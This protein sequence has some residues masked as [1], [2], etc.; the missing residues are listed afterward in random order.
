MYSA[1]QRRMISLDQIG[2]MDCCPRDGSFS[3]T[4]DSSPDQLQSR[5][6]DRHQQSEELPLKVKAPEGGKMKVQLCRNFI[7]SGYCPYGGKCRFAHG[8]KQLLQNSELSSN[9]RTKNCKAFYVGGECRY[10][11]RCNFKHDDRKLCD[12]HKTGGLCRFNLIQ[13][14]PDLFVSI[15]K[16]PLF[17]FSVCIQS[18]PPVDS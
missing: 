14:Y 1:K 16:K 17:P 13:W 18:E 11:D 2:N 10:G 3:S 8:L 9:F 6:R 15:K 12:I 5:S 7:A 4:D